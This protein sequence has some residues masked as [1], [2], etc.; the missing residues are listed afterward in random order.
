MSA[1]SAETP[2]SGGVSG[3]GGALEI[4]EA[5]VVVLD[6]FAL[7]SFVS[8]EAGASRVQQVLSAAEE[9]RCRALLSL[10]SLTETAYIVERRHGLPGTQRILSLIEDLPVEVVGVDRQAALA[11]A[12]IKAHHAMS[13]ADAFVAALAL[14]EGGTILTGDPEFRSV[15]Q[16][17]PMEWLPV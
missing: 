15:E 3:S 1:A 9:G 8:D 10:I 12:H 14:A 16:L 11:A 2:G 6:S 13:L 17:V 4:A 5:P 7:V